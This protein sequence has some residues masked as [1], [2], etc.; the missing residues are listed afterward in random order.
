MPIGY[1]TLEEAD[2]YFADRLNADP[3]VGLDES[4]PTTKVQALTTAVLRLDQERYQGRR[5][6]PDQE[7]AWPRAGVRD[8]DGVRVA[9]D[10]VPAGIKRAQMELALAM[11]TEDLLSDTGLEGFEEVQVG[12]LRVKARSGPAGALPA[13]VRREL[14]G[15]LVGSPLQFQVLRS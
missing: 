5:T 4:P 6:D 8:A 13:Q 9:W 15:F 11:L 3:W 10:A 2:A 12:P 14:Q 7:H 1:V